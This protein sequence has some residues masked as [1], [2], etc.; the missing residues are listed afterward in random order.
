MRPPKEQKAHG[1]RAATRAAAAAAATTDATVSLT[2]YHT[3]NAERQAGA[4][5]PPA[6]PTAM[7]DNNDSIYE[8]SAALKQKRL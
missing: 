6:T 8:A 4:T 2:Y 5:A 3:I 7:H 1:R